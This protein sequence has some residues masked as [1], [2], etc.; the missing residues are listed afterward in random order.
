MKL[1]SSKSL[2]VLFLI[3][4]VFC[5]AYIWVQVY[6]E[7]F[8]GARPDTTQTR[9]DGKT[10]VAYDSNN[11]DLTYHDTILD[12]DAKPTPSSKDGVYS[13]SPPINYVPNYE[14]SI[15]LGNLSKPTTA[16]ADWSA[17]DGDPGYSPFSADPAVTDAMTD[18]PTDPPKPTTTASTVY[19]P[20]V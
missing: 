13:T 17:Y 16:A 6:Y 9:A 12:V 7:G 14:N 20:N 2:V 15:Y 3:L 5:I 1:R 4:L 19:L 8:A 18:T 11:Y 10:T